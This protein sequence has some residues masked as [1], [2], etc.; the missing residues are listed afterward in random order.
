MM[1]TDG[2]VSA[3]FDTSVCYWCLSASLM[4]NRYRSPPIKQTENM[5]L[6]LARAL[7]V[8]QCVVDT[9]HGWLTATST[10]SHQ[11]LPFQ[12]DQVKPLFRLCILPTFKMSGKRN[13]NDCT[14][15]FKVK[16]F[17]DDSV[18][19]DVLKQ[20]KKF[21]SKEPKH[22]RHLSSKGCKNGAFVKK[23]HVWEKKSSMQVHDRNLATKPGST[24]QH[25][26]YCVRHCITCYREPSRDLEG[27]YRVFPVGTDDNPS[28][29]PQALG[30]KLPPV[31]T[32][33]STDLG[34]TRPS[35]RR[36]RPTSLTLKRSVDSLPEEPEEPSMDT[37]SEPRGEFEQ[38]ATRPPTRP[39]AGKILNVEVGVGFL[40]LALMAVISGR[41]CSKLGANGSEIP[42]GDPSIKINNAIMAISSSFEERRVSMCTEHYELGALSAVRKELRQIQDLSQG[43]RD[44]RYVPIS[45]VH[46]V[47]PTFAS[48]TPIDPLTNPHP[49]YLPIKV[50]GGYGFSAYQ[51]W[52]ELLNITQETQSDTAPNVLCKYSLTPLFLLGGGLVETAPYHW[53]E[54][55]KEWEYIS[56]LVTCP[57]DQ[58]VPTKGTLKAGRRIYFDQKRTS[59]LYLCQE[60]CAA[61]RARYG[62][63]NESLECTVSNDCY[64]T[65]E[66]E[67][68]CY[69]YSYNFG[70]KKDF[71]VMYPFM[72][73]KSQDLDSSWDEQ[74]NSG[75]TASYLCQHPALGG[76][77]TMTGPHNTMLSV[78][79][80]CGYVHRPPPD[81][82]VWSACPQAA[83]LIEGMLSNYFMVLD[84]L[85]A[86]IR[87][88]YSPLPTSSGHPTT[89]AK[90]HKK[91][92]QIGG[93]AAST[94]A[95][96]TKF[97]SF[98]SKGLTGLSGF[99]KA[100]PIV[101]PAL[102]L[103]LITASAILPSIIELAADNYNGDLQFI[104]SGL[105]AGNGDYIDSPLW[106]Q[107]NDSNLLYM[108]GDPFDERWKRWALPARIAKV[109]A[110]LRSVSKDIKSMVEYKQP[111]I[112]SH[113]NTLKNVDFTYLTVADENLTFIKKV[114]YF[115]QKDQNIAPHRA[116]ALLSLDPSLPLLEGS[117]L[118]IGSNYGGVSW[119]CVDSHLAGQTLPESCWDNTRLIGTTTLSIPF[120]QDS[121][122][123][124]FL[125]KGAVEIR[126]PEGRW[127]G[128]SVGTLVTLISPHCR[129]TADNKDAFMPQ[130]EANGLKWDGNMKGGFKIL[131]HDHDLKSN[132]S[133][134]F[135]S[136]LKVRLLQVSHSTLYSTDYLV[137]I[138]IFLLLGIFFAL[139]VL[140]RRQI[141]LR[142]TQQA[143]SH[144]SEAELKTIVD[145]YKCPPKDAM[146]PRMSNLDSM[147]PRPPRWSD[148]KP[149]F[150]EIGGLKALTNRTEMV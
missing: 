14:S 82:M 109:G 19:F 142:V 146:P 72:D 84:D 63:D 5:P 104:D 29:P 116:S 112:Y 52:T 110:Q 121:Y 92:L 22:Q 4:S 90:T 143:L 31:L 97:V 135:P 139:T 127:S 101:G 23:G 30:H 47:C 21:S 55:D 8:P 150:S 120:V 64:R 10:R 128:F 129:V 76:T 106:K 53:V 122:L 80:A 68:S 115:L 51:T 103:G 89:A 77:L 9:H 131:F 108:S 2:V 54:W 13:V 78:R 66:S 118:S 117:S 119:Q 56:R 86:S 24:S 45:A 35:A 95:S 25:T 39:L 91:I 70:G 7:A 125:G 71:C 145:S 83:D 79:K 99:V 26:K 126:C 113:I 50:T 1:F 138:V 123:L 46:S 37:P 144:R 102:S 105:A 149:T 17:P 16:H 147:A 74:S 134:P 57:A 111:L 59:N 49:K 28:P 15:R 85:E 75:I 93:R 96:N 12:T 137:Y 87:A 11:R 100:I 98:L 58:P 18:H 148:S 88:S 107:D 20:P 81:L 32:R 40:V 43:Y 130:F 140:T 132:I 61:A 136:S 62:E 44:P 34:P 3:L 48:L 42:M 33:R 69:W 73:I 94:L 36:Y 38:H 67:K 65:T 133:F 27:S 60:A 41:I 6:W 141:Q 114:F 124:K